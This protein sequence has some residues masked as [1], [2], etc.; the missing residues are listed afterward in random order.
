LNLI[1]C[2]LSHSHDLLLKID[3]MA[4]HQSSSRVQISIDLSQQGRQIGDL[5]LKWS[6]NRQPLGYYPV[7]IICLSNG[8]GPT[9]L[10]N[11]GV[12]GDEF[13]GPV[14]LMRLVQTLSLD[15]INGRIIIVPALNTAAVQASS[16]VSPIG[17]LNL[18]RAFPGDADGSLTQMITHFMETVLL[19][20]CDAVIDLHTGGKAAIFAPCVLDQVDSKSPQGEANLALAKAFATPYL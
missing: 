10:L 20:Q 13:E 6:D 17:Q 1:L 3:R 4:K 9:V 16:R 12:H 19:P 18:N 7:P 8:A 14:T 2:S 11:G 5:K 15:A